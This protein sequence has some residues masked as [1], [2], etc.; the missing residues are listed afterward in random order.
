M[1]VAI[2]VCGSIMKHEFASCVG[3]INL[4]ID[5]L[6]IPKLLDL[7]LAYDRVG[8]LVEFCLWQIDSFTI[9]SPHFL[10]IF[11]FFS[12]YLLLGLLQSERKL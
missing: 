2:S 3:L 8:S 10:S 7:G 1:Q 4:F 5:F 11:S 12:L 6:V 9:L